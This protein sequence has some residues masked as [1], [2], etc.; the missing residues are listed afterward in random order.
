MAG[1]NGINLTP[2]ELAERWH[3]SICTLANK[4]VDGSGCPYIKFGRRVLY[5]LAEVEK[6]EKKHMR[7]AVHVAT[8]G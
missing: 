1:M 5:P 6:F 7:T 4:R 3:T 8:P 2:H